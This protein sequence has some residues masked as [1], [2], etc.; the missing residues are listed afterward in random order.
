MNLAALQTASAVLET[1]QTHLQALQVAYQDA[2]ENN[3]SPDLVQFVTPADSAN[4]DRRSKIA[5][6]AFA[7]LVAGLVLGVALAS[8]RSLASSPRT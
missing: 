1:G 3:P 6:F 7:G 4:S 5:L 8:L 2:V